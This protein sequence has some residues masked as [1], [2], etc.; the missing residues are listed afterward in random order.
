MTNDAG[1]L[2]H[3]SVAIAQTIAVQY[4]PAF[5]RSHDEVLGFY[6][7]NAVLTWNGQNLSGKSE[8]HQYFKTLPEVSIQVAGFEVQTVPG[9]NLMTMLVVF[10]SIEAPGNLIR[11]FH[12]TFYI[13]S[14][15]E[16]KEALIR[17][18]TFQLI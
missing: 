14:M 7:N 6:S 13:E 11:D 18:H 12:S 3:D 15:P 9:T 1:P 16:K 2:H 5:M 17:Y 10:G 4:F 8:I